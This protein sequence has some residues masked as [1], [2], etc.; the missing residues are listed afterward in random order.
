MVWRFALAVV[1]V[2]L[3][4]A[5]VRHSEPERIATALQQ[6]L[7]WLVPVLLL[8][9]GHIGT[10]VWTTRLLLGKRALRIAGWP[11]WRIHFMAYALVIVMPLGR[12]AGEA[13]KATLLAP[14]VRGVR[15][16]TMATTMQAVMLVAN[17]VASL[18]AAVWA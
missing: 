11:M 5:V 17:A 8:E 14:Q 9:A 7:P 4:A 15:A 1:G 16:A 12:A 13:L 18:V 6:A 2:A 10:E 3:L